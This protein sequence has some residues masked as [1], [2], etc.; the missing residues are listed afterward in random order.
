MAQTIKL[1]RSST[2]GAEPSTSDLELGEVAINTYDGKMFIKK[3][4]GSDSI[5]ELG[6]G[7][8]GEA[9]YVKSTVTATQGQTTVTGLTYTA[10]LVDVYLNG[11][12]LVV[13]QDVTATNGTSIVLASGANL[14]DIIQIVAF[15]AS[16]AFTPASPTFTGTVT[17]PTINASTALKIAGVAVTSTAS[18]LNL[19]DGVTTTAAELNILDEATI[20]TT[21]LNKLDGLTATT[22]ELNLTAGLTATTLELNKLDGAT[23]STV[24]LNTLTGLTSNTAELNLLDGVT[25]TTLELNKLDGVTASTAE[26]NYVDGVT[27]NIQTQIDAVVPGVHTIPF[28]ANGAIAANKPVILQTDGKVAEVAIADRTRTTPSPSY[29]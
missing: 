29:V 13:G 16:A 1:K 2:S 7:G 6:T 4:D 15:K 8:G 9:T 25:A 3:N 18:E 28:T 23:C 27:S 21:E 5:V 19:L 22:A 11:A 10:G 14:N 17:A 24:E 26:L 20:T 12:K